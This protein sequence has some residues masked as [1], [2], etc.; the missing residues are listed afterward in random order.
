MPKKKKIFPPIWENQED[1]PIYKLSEDRANFIKEI[2]KLTAEKIK[3]KYPENLQDVLTKTAYLELIRIKEEPWKIDPPNDKAYWKKIQKAIAKYSRKK[4]DAKKKKHDDILDSIVNRYSEEIVSTFRIPTFL[5]VRKFLTIFFGR[6]LNTAAARNFSRIWSTEHRLENRLI[7]KGEVEKVRELMKQGTVVVLPTH[8][9]NLDSI[10]IGYILDRFAGLPL[11][12]YGAGLNLFNSGWAAYFMNRVGTYR[13]DRRK[14]NPIYLEV[15]KSQSQ[16]MIE[17]GVNC[18]FFPGGTRSRSGSL[19]ANVKLG[20]MGTMLQAQRAIYERGEEQKVFVVPVVVNYHFVLEAKYLI[21]QHLRKTGKEKYLKTSDQF[22]SWRKRLKFLWEFFSESNEI[23]LSF[24]KPM[25]VVGNFVDEKG[26]SFDPRGNSVELKDYFM[27]DGVV[28]QNRQRERE[29]TKHLGEKIVRRFHA[30]NIVLTSHLTAYA[31]FK[32][33]EKEHPELDIY[34]LLRLPTDEYVFSQE[35]LF[36]KVEV[37]KKRLFELEKAEKIKLSD[38]IR[39][40]AEK[41]VKDGV[42][43][44]GTYHAQK[45]LK[46]TKKGELVC[47]MF[48]ILYFYHNRLD[49]YELEKYFAWNSTEIKRREEV[50]SE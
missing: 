36:E 32:I 45:P 49:S 12:S 48:R 44:M 40:P 28:Q 31:A 41:I 50:L 18:I 14:K 34:G 33:F 16:M 22:Y 24:G 4:D 20:L 27:T 42:R 35:L 21:E 39:L 9:S 10:L 5:F 46:F 2:D 6:L 23:T 29:Y 13:V 17:R 26:V 19:E 8:H 37:L 11:F 38:E 3:E 1:W 15:L 43:K 7:L 30:E 25:D 47:E